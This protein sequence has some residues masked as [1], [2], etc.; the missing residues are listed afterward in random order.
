MYFVLLIQ[1]ALQFVRKDLISDKPASNQAMVM[2]L[3]GG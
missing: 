3:I 1:M 2:N